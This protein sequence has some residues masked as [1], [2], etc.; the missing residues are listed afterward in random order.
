MLDEIRDKHKRIKQCMRYIQV[1][2]D[3]IT[4]KYEVG[5]LKLELSKAKNVEYKGRTEFYAK[6]L[7]VLG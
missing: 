6:A 3:A 7:S 2:E 5:K 4:Y 1:M